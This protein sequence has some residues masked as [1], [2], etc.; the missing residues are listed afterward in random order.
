MNNDNELTYNLDGKLTSLEF[1]V[2]KL[3][4]LSD[5]LNKSI[6]RLYNQGKTS[7][8]ISS[9]NL[10][11]ITALK[12]DVDRLKQSLTDNIQTISPAELKTGQLSR[13]NNILSNL[14]N[15]NNNFNDNYLYKDKIIRN[16]D[17]KG[18]K[19]DNTYNQ[20]LLHYNSLSNE[21]QSEIN[22][23]ISMMS[24]V[25]SKSRKGREYHKVDNN[26][27]NY[28]N[29]NYDALVNKGLIKDS[30]TLINETIGKYRSYSN[31][32]NAQIIKDTNL[33]NSDNVTPGEIQSAMNRIANNKKRIQSINKYIDKQ[34]KLLQRLLDT[35]SDMT[36]E[37][38]SYNKAVSDGNV[39]VKSGE[40]SFTGTARKYS[41]SITSG[42]VLGAYAQTLG[43]LAKG[44]QLRINNYNN[45]IGGTMM[46]LA[47]DGDTTHSLDNKI[48]KDMDS[49]GIKNGTNTTSEENSK[50]LGAYT[51]S[52]RTGN[53]KDYHKQT[54]AA[55]QF[56]TFTGAGVNSTSNLIQAIGN[57]GGTNPADNLETMYGSLMNSNMV[58]RAGEQTEALG[59][60]L[61]N[62][63][64]IGNMST[65]NINDTIGMQQQLAASGDSALQG[66][67]G[68]NAINNATDVITNVGN[69]TMRN[70]ASEV[71]G[72][73]QDTQEGKVKLSLA[74]EDA[75]KDPKKLSKLI[76][77][78]TKFYGDD[79]E[80][81]AEYIARQSGGKVSRRQALRI[82]KLAKEGKLSKKELKKITDSDKKMGKTRKN[83]EDAIHGS[84]NF[85]INLYLAVDQKVQSGASMSADGF[86]RLGNSMFANHPILGKMFAFGGSVIGS[87]ISS[88][89]ADWASNKVLDAWDNHKA[90]KEGRV[91]SS[92]SSGKE[93]KHT[94]T[95]KEEF[96]ASEKPKG[97]KGKF[98]AKAKGFGK[99]TL[100]T[101]G[102]QVAIDG[103][104]NM[105]S[106]KDSSDEEDKPENYS[107]G[108]ELA[109][110]QQSEDLEHSSET[111]EKRD[112]I[113]SDEIDKGWDNYFSRGI[114]VVEQAMAMPNIINT[115][116]SSSSSSS[117]DS[118]SDTDSDSKDKKDSK[119]KNK[120]SDGSTQESTDKN[121]DKAIKDADDATKNLDKSI[122]KLT[123]FAHGGTSKSG[124]KIDLRQT[125]L[126]KDYLVSDTGKRPQGAF[127]ESYSDLRELYSKSNTYSNSKVDTVDYK[128]TPEFNVDLNIKRKDNYSKYVDAVQSALEKYVNS[129]SE[130]L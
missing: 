57:V 37:F 98:K 63:A 126:L 48:E 97:T 90:K 107:K 123:K 15:I 32:A 40:Y 55:S 64:N 47:N 99:A 125:E 61:N 105:F 23:L 87:A 4:Q 42:I 14:N 2:S 94:S 120:K 92:N 28:I 18:F 83:L 7:G 13:L 124:G 116:G 127:D 51:S 76:N 20:D 129:L 5:T 102:T 19:P 25:K 122:D 59:S 16:F 54:V 72:I 121:I 1:D 41:A 114:R 17:L 119:D 43:A 104:A 103:I 9:N 115:S 46:A 130:I 78:L 117:S 77:G 95:P 35:E 89:I 22:T 39:R 60:I 113:N 100:V 58:N 65:Q 49:L 24:D 44:K 50:L 52:N 68:A 85:K 86:R 62:N 67:Q 111:K 69:G 26:Y 6:D 34:E 31:D 82:T 8:T 96:V 12:E 84:G 53:V 80:Q 27:D 101:V 3:S 70:I 38:N 91:S 108:K 33:V 88:G 21:T 106:K 73:S 109:K 112:K 11:T 10:N 74:M 75:K 36:K 118:D 71:F 66:K 79:E 110:K 30:K 29:K 56:S 81:S 128:V 93:T 45:G